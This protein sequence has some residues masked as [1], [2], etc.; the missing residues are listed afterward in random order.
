MNEK[1]Q[2]VDRNQ[3]KAEAATNHRTWEGLV[4]A[5]IRKDQEDSDKQLKK[6]DIGEGKYILVLRSRLRVL[7]LFKKKYFWVKTKEFDAILR[8]IYST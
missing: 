5:N 4:R 8:F 2:N 7:T 1:D 3:P 6:S